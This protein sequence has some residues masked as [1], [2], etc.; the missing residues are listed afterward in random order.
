MKRRDFLGVTT[1]S[2]A[3]VLGAGATALGTFR[4][5]FPAWLLWIPAFYIT[6]LHVVFVS[7]IRYRAP[8][9]IC[10]AV[11]AAWVLCKMLGHIRA[12][13]VAKRSDR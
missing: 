11:P 6:A 9:M 12:G 5:G 1:L 7:S 8:A 3:A 4:R 10:F 2:A 13:N